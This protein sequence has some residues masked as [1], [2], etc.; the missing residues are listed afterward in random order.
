L[1]NPQENFIV[2]LEGKG[3]VIICFKNSG[4]TECTVPSTS[5]IKNGE[6]SLSDVGF[7]FVLLGMGADITIP[8]VYTIH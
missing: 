5:L 1:S 4:E 6:A 3:G 8:H 2:L 7:C